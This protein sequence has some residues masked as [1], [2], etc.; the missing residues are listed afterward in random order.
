MALCSTLRTCT[1]MR[2]RET[3]RSA[4][5]T[6]AF[7]PRMRPAT[8]FSFCGLT[9]SIRRTAWASLSFSTRSRLGLPILSPLC[10]F[11]GRVPVVDPRR[12]ELAELVADH[13]LG[14]GH[15]D[16]LMA[17]INAEREADE[18]RQDRRAAAPDLD[19]LVTAR[20]AGLLRFLQHI[21]VE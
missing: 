8:R 16:V 6:E 7:L 12:R 3:S 9:R 10:L 1:A 17:V 2:L 18:L 19:H 13:V 5:A 15:R 20:R 11:V 14:H 4:S 21:A